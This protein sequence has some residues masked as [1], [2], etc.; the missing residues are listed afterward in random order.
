MTCERTP[1]TNQDRFDRDFGSGLSAD[2]RP[3][4]NFI[5]VEVRGEITMVSS[6]ELRRILTPLY[7]GNKGIIVDL[8]RVSAMDSSGVATLVEGLRWRRRTQKAFILIG[9]GSRIHD[10]FSLAK[11]DTSFI[12]LPDPLTD[13]LS[14]N[15]TYISA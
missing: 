4:K 5:V 11:L 2:I 3:L 10:L 13:F 14:E 9:V 15:P 12:L 6:P 1:E 8:S 7:S